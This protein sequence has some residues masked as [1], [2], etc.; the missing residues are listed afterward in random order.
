MFV[1]FNHKTKRT[2]IANQ[3]TIS[4]CVKKARKAKENKT[5]ITVSF[6]IWQPNLPDTSSKQ[7][8]LNQSLRSSHEVKY[9]YTKALLQERH[10]KYEKT[11]AIS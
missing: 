8:F 4:K 2:K 7:H 6:P 1:H 5:V 10:M 3:N 11:T 9:V